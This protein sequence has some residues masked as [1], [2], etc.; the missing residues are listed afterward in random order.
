MKKLLM[1]AGALCAILIL[2][3]LASATHFELFDVKADCEGFTY[4]ATVYYRYTIYDVDVD[5]SF[6]LTDEKGGEVARIEGVAPV[7]RT[8][9]RLGFLTGG[10][11]WGVDLC[12]TYTVTA[13]VHLYSVYGTDLFDEDTLTFETSL[14]C[15]CDEPGDEPCHRTPGYWKNHARNWPQDSLMVGGEERSKRALIRVLRTP[16]RGDATII[17]AKHLIAAKLNVLNGTDDGINDV[18]ADADAYLMAHP[19]RSRPRGAD[20]DEA[21]RLKDLLADYN[22]LECNTPCDRD[23]DNHH[24]P[25]DKAMSVTEETTF[26]NLKALYK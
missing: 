19:L 24:G 11:V 18:I 1:L 3:G 5:Y 13:S 25:R 22:E 4:D 26:D 9:D 2:P 10:D 16:V 7:T 21:L 8:D 6:V 23:D 17:L 14:V 15:E 12:G 20:K